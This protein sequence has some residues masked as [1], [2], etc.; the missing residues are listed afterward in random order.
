M[1]TTDT[2]ASDEYAGEAPHADH[3]AHQHQHP[4]DATYVKLA[5]FLAVLTAAEVATYFIQDPSTSLLVAVLFP[6][7]G[8]S[9]PSPCTSSS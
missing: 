7:M 9:W 1:S 2:E 6:M 8:S 5:I 4:T 3:E